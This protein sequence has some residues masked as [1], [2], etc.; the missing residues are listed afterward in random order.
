MLSFACPHCGKRLQI[1]AE[2]AGQKGKCPFCRQVLTIPRS[3]DP[4][5]AGD[6]QPGAPEPAA[7]RQGDDPAMRAPAG[8]L[9][10]RTSVVRDGQVA[11]TLVNRIMGRAGWLPLLVAAALL[12][13]DYKWPA[14]GIRSFYSHLPTDVA[15]RS[16]EQP[17]E[18]PLLD[19]ALV[20]VD[21]CLEAEAA[22]RPGEINPAA[23]MKYVGKTGGIDEVSSLPP[24]EQPAPRR[25]AIPP[26]KPGCRH[27]VL[28]WRGGYFHYDEGSLVGSVGHI[29][30]FTIGFADSDERIQLGGDRHCLAVATPC[31]GT[32]LA[33]DLASGFTVGGWGLRTGGISLGVDT[34]VPLCLDL[35]AQAGDRYDCSITVAGYDQPC[36]KRHVL[37][38]QIAALIHS[39]TLTEMP[40][41]SW[42]FTSTD[43]SAP[44]GEQVAR[45]RISTSVATTRTGV[46]KLYSTKQVLCLDEPAKC[47]SVYL[48]GVNHLAV[49]VPHVYGSAF[50]TDNLAIAALVLTNLPED[51]KYV[52]T[53]N[54]QKVARFSLG[55]CTGS[56][57]TATTILLLVVILACTA[58]VV[59]AGSAVFSGKVAGSGAKWLAVG[60]AGALAVLALAVIYWWG[61]YLA[62]ISFTAV[63][64]WFWKSLH[65]VGSAGLLL[66]IFLTAHL[67]KRFLPF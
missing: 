58:G 32:Y 39:G 6:G 56:R 12:L 40:E 33:W 25:L 51:K 31:E 24:A 65:L 66:A 14:A 52:L 19:K 36:R 54:G 4:P 22:F 46:G 7:P 42:E 55:S 5:A 41:L 9:A 21:K 27:L 3:S 23:L 28:A 17:A 64:Y 20:S 8:D 44:P 49:M 45:F 63:S 30:G 2:S 37:P 60:A 59:A 47:E 35:V 62:A 61:A 57:A 16:F 13:I 18:V 10:V 53:R 67:T 34:G 26:A 11:D 15:M 1:S 50:V 43:P 29:A 38:E 48:S